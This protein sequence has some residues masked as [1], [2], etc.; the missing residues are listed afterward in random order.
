MAQSLP[1]LVPPRV[2]VRIVCQSSLNQSSLPTSLLYDTI[3][4]D[5]QRNAMNTP[6]HAHEHAHTRTHARV[7]TASAKRARASSAPSAR[8]SRGS[9]RSYLRYGGG[10]RR[11]GGTLHPTLRRTEPSTSPHFYPAEAQE[12]PTRSPQQRAGKDLAAAEQLAT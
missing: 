1:S 2:V 4:N 6:T 5:T 8:S 12:G 10:W 3:R 7:R 9:T 11:A